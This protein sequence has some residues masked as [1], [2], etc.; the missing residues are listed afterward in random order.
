MSAF[1]LCWTVSYPAYLIVHPA[2]VYFLLRSHLIPRPV[3][4]CVKFSLLLVRLLTI[5]VSRPA[6]L[7]P[8]L[9]L[10]GIAYFPK[11]VGTFFGL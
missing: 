9:V 11:I 1:G 10:P 5:L 3:L 8:V 2:I 7:L 6:V 4:L